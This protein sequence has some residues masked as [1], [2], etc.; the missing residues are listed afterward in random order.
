METRD[1]QAYL[2][3]LWRIKSNGVEWRAQLVR[4]DT[5][6]KVGFPSM[7]A[8][9]QFLYSLEQAESP[10]LEDLS[11]PKED[12]SGDENTEGGRVD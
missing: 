4:V 2:L 3:R 1:Y 10:T 6:E 11:P 5:G 7:E 12:A 8:L 9:I